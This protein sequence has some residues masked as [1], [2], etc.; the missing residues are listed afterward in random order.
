MNEKDRCGSCAGRKTLSV[1]KVLEV[2]VDKGMKE[3]QKIYFRGE[4]DQQVRGKK[5][6]TILHVSRLLYISYTKSPLQ[7]LGVVA[8]SPKGWV[9][10]V[11]IVQS[12]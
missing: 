2:N 6:E 1:K 11:K 4:G 3:M 9:K 7:G 10:N 5:I 12:T 8:N